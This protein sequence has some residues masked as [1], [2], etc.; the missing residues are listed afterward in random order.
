MMIRHY[1]F[2]KWIAPLMFLAIFILSCEG[3]GEKGIKTRISGKF[4]AFKDKVVTLSEID[5]AKATPLDTLTAT[6]KGSFEF[7]FRRPGPGFYLVKFDNRN[8]ITLILDQEKSVEISSDLSEIRKGYQVEGSEDSKYYCQFE[9]FLETNR[10]K[11][12]SLS[13]MYNEYQRSAGFQSLKL[14]MDDNYREIFENQRNYSIAFL[15]NHCSSLASL[16]IINRRFGQRKI[17]DEQ[18]DYDYFIMIDSC[19]S[20]KYP[21]NKHLL[22]FHKKVEE[23]EQRKQFDDLADAKL[24]PGKKVPDISLGNSVGKQVS[25]YSLKGSPVIMT[26]WSSTDKTSR[27]SNLQLKDL[28]GRNKIPGIRVYAIGLESYKDMWENSIRIDGISDWTNVTD[29]LGKYSSATSLYNVPQKL[30]YFILLDK[31]LVIQYKGSNIPE[32]EMKLKGMNP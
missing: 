14:E 16:L 6:D 32:L 15:N 13:T 26:F 20:L 24:Q 7:K 12:D 21:E 28:I 18:M 17:M 5:I 10:K 8:Y 4:P 19:L 25:L 27:Q 9:L 3:P 23:M 2:I 31:E 1:K 29:L 11:V 22:A 30:P